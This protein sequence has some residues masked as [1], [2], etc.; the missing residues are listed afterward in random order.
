MSNF[1]SHGILNLVLT[2]S[3]FVFQKLN[4]EPQKEPSQNKTTQAGLV[5]CWVEPSQRVRSSV[6]LT[7]WV[8][9]LVLVDCQMNLSSE[10][11]EVQFFRILGL[12]LAPLWP[13]R[14]KIWFWWMN[15]GL[16][17]FGVRFVK[18]KVRFIRV[19]SNTKI[20]KRF[21]LAILKNENGEIQ[22]IKRR[23]LALGYHLPIQ[24]DIG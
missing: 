12:G 2:N 17:E 13:N 6:F 5:L 14:F 9:I 24:V 16:S 8:R 18:F 21:L 22:G 7:G 1:P 23:H 20:A 11:Y 4:I 3:R 10:G 15:L 19:R